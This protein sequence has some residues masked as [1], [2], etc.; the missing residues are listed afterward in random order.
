MR[1]GADPYRYFISSGQGGNRPDGP[2]SVGIVARATQ[3][4]EKKKR[5]AAKIVGNHIEIVVEGAGEWVTDAYRPVFTS[6]NS[7]LTMLSKRL[8]VYYADD[9]RWKKA[10]EWTRTLFEHEIYLDKADPHD[11]ALYYN[12]TPDIVFIV[13]PDFTHSELAGE[14]TNRNGQLVFVEKPFDSQARNVDALLKALGRNRGTTVLGL[15]HYQFRAHGLRDI[16]PNVVEH[17]GGALAKIEF[18]MTETQPLEFRR[19]RTLQYGLTLDML[20]H[21]LAMLTVFGD[22]KSIDDIQVLDAGRYGPEF[23]AKDSEKI[24][25]R[26]VEIWKD[27]PAYFQRETYSKV[28]FTFE[29]YSGNHFRVPCTAVVGKGFKSDVKY[30]QV[31]GRNGNSVRVEFRPTPK[32]D[33]TPGYPWGQ[34]IFLLGDNKTGPQGVAAVETSKEQYYKQLLADLETGTWATLGSTLLP[35]PEARAIVAALDRIWWAIED[36]KEERGKWGE[37]TLQKTQPSDL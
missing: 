15:D 11:L 32:S 17:V 4:A 1:P 37:I 18:Y 20:P 22:V 31:T 14:W 10:P 3:V 23:K 2:D 25:G 29:D 26:D 13:T 28:R 21:M 27:V 24:D 6:L 7:R 9:S 5:L 35:D 36:F 16:L 30:F 33:P 8:S 34:I 12:L 19:A